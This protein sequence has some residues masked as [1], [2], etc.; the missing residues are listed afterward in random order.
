MVS[1]VTGAISP[2]ACHRICHDTLFYRPIRQRNERKVC[3]VEKVGSQKHTNTH[4]S[5]RFD[6]AGKPKPENSNQ[7]YGQRCRIARVSD[8]AHIAAIAV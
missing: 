3:P 6:I 2:R 4:E 5:E 1:N 8:I 7:P